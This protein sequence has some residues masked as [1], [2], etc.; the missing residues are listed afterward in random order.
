MKNL[1][2]L[3]N[4][5]NPNMDHT[6]KKAKTAKESFFDLT[7]TEGNMD[8]Q[9]LKFNQRT[10]GT[11]KASSYNKKVIGNQNCCFEIGPN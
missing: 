1:Q 10:M 2:K 4:N 5:D 6:Y 3:K 7:R 8:K 11:K 9:E